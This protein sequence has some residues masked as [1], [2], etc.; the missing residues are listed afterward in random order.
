MSIIH[1]GT[2]EVVIVDDEDMG[3]LSR[4]KWRAIKPS[5]SSPWYAVTKVNG[6]LLYMHRFLLKAQEGQLCDHRNGNGLDNRKF[7]LR[8]CNAQQ[9]AWNIK[10]KSNGTTSKHKGVGWVKRD[11]KFQAR[12]RTP[13]GRKS[14]GYFETEEVAALAYN[15]MA[16]K[17]FGPFAKLN[18]VRV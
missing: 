8:L 18:I 11:H 17:V 2:N 7:N 9:S 15:S 6:N 13:Q 4:F 10:K 16:R 1:L 14:L 5:R 3:E 12:I